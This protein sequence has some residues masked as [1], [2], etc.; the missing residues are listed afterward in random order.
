MRTVNFSEK[1]ENDCGVISSAHRRIYQ[2]S[3]IYPVKS[4][5]TNQ[6][7]IIY[8]FEDQ[9]WTRIRCLSFTIISMRLFCVDLILVFGRREIILGTNV[10][11]RK[12]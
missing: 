9:E 7:R 8:K 10:S 4:S 5:V 3:M 1:Y 2:T 12:K 11:N 6:G